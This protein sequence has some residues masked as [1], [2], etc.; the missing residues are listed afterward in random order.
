[1]FNVNIIL[2]WKITLE[3]THSIILKK[4]MA[5]WPVKRVKTVA[6][7]TPNIYKKNADTEKINIQMPTHAN[8]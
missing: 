1:M 8:T 5:G 3:V 2:P 7:E 4:I 6:H